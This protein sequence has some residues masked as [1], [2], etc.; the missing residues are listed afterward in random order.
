MLKFRTIS[1]KYHVK[2]VIQLDDRFL[3]LLFFAICFLF[4]CSQPVNG[5]VGSWVEPVPG[6]PGQVQGIRI[7]AEGKALSINMQTLVYES[8]EQQGDQI[9]LTGKSIGNRQTISF[10]D[11]FEIARLTADS[12]VFRKGDFR[13]IYTRVSRN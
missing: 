7:E 11:T 6:Q 1:S 2:A 5:I 13:R 9:I 12:L 10:S 4:S 3:Y 8:W